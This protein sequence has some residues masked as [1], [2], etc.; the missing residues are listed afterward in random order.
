MTDGDSTYGAPA[1]SG[2]PAT[3]AARAADASGAA[4][5]AGA[6]TAV[7]PPPQAALKRHRKPTR[8]RAP[9]SAGDMVRLVLRGVGQTLITAGCVVLLFVVYEVYITNIFSHRLQHRVHNQLEEEWANGQDPL[10]LPGGSQSTIPLGSGIANI[11]IPRFGRDYAFT[12]VQGADDS[13]LEKGPGHYTETALPGDVGNFAIAGH[14]VGKGEPF[15]N[16]DHLRPGDAVII[17]TKAKWYVYR[18]EGNVQTR[19]LSQKDKNGVPGREIV[20]PGDGD[21]KDPVPDNP[22]LAPAAA[23]TPNVAYLTMTTCHPKFTATQRMIVHATL[24]A[25]LT[26]PRVGTTMPGSISALY[27]EGN[28]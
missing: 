14:R 22:G 12:I 5:G 21:V 25:S 13:A 8:H 27:T 15:L 4:G 23:P 17:E 20:S 18:V 26:T 1:G 9:M 11:Y 7:A 10:A 3:G 19:D 2:T 6:A 16:L 24:Q 28:L